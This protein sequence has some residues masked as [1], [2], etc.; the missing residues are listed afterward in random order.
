MVYLGLFWGLRVVDANGDNHTYW[1]WYGMAVLETIIITG[2]S[3]RYRNLSFEGTHL[4]ERMSL[5]TL[6]I[7]GEG[8]IATAKACQY[9][10]YSDGVFTFSGSVGASIFCAVLILYFLYM[11]YFDFQNEEYS[12]TIRTQIWSAL[13]F[14]LHLALVLAVE[15]VSQ[16]IM[17]N[18]AVVKS[19]SLGVEVFGKLPL[20]LDSSNA[21][22]QDFADAATSLNATAHDLITTQLQ[23][24]TSSLSTSQGLGYL[25]QVVI[26]ATPT[27]ANGT[28]DFTAAGMPSG[29]FLPS[30]TPPF[31]RSP[32]LIVVIHTRRRTE[33]RNTLMRPLTLP[34]MNLS[35]GN[36][37]LGRT[38]MRDGQCS[39][40]HS[41]TSSCRLGWR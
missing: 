37:K 41:P 20:F 3:M 36:V 22:T 35:T 15:D 17:W 12:G 23:R 34:N 29:G 39:H 18:A 16:N 2:I 33:R 4:V 8:A 1:T 31:S 28:E 26:S 40:S 6:I 24:S 14:P 7:L 38:S 25:G 21:T 19:K 10:A 32:A 11:I 13:H 5:L 9:I 27:I 30:S